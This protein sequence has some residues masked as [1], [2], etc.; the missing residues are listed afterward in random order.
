MKRYVQ[1]GDSVQAVRILEQAIRDPVSKEDWRIWWALANVSSV[2]EVKQRAAS[3]VVRL[4]SAYQPARQMLSELLSQA[5]NISPKA[6]RSQTQRTRSSQARSLAPSRTASHRRS[7]TSWMG[8]S[9]ALILAVTFL[10][11][12]GLL[13]IRSTQPG[14]TAR[15]VPTFAS[16]LAA[17]VPTLTGRP[18]STVAPPVTVT[19]VPVMVAAAPTRSIFERLTIPVSDNAARRFFQ[20]PIRVFINVSDEIWAPAL[21]LALI[22]LNSAFQQIDPR[23]SMEQVERAAETDILIQV[24]SRAEYRA[25]DACPFGTDSL[26]CGWIVVLETPTDDSVPFSIQGQVRIVNDSPNSVGTLLHELLHALGIGEHSG[27]P[28]DIMYPRI[29]DKVRLAPG[30]ITRLRALYGT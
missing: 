16:T 17:P 22:E 27:D 14:D 23:F 3:R 2:R 24:M 10:A 6:N 19:A 30:D 28:A 18:I 7:S 13:I 20:S 15:V 25:W 9:I 5:N 4:N 8:G 12:A 29:E 1:I 26:A 11:A 21:D